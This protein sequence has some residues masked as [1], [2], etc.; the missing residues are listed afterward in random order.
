MRG[1]R[2][3]YPITKEMP[4]NKPGKFAISVDPVIVDRYYVADHLATP[5]TVVVDC[6]PANVY[7][8]DPVG[9]PRD[10]HIAGAKSLPFTELFDAANTIKSDEQLQTYFNTIADSKN[11]ELV[12]YCFIGQKP[13]S[14]VYLA[15]RELL[16]A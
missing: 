14:V 1:R 8:G 3:G 10:G 15:G 13:A 12:T 6:R 11:K 7:N 5:G 4:P 16:G 2:R 9:Y